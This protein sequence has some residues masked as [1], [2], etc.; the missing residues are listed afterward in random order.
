MT[1]PSDFPGAIA[2]IG[3]RSQPE[4][5]AT[6]AFGFILLGGVLVGAQV[7]DIRLANELVRRGYPVHVWW[8]FDRMRDAP[9]D[10][11]I[12][13]HWLFSAA[14]YSCY[15][16]SW[17]LNDRIGRLISWMF[18]DQ[19]RTRIVQRLSWFAAQQIQAVI[20]LACGGIERD[21]RLA[22]RF[23]GE[24]DRHQITHVLPNLEILALFAQAARQHASS[25]FKCLVTFQGYE[26]YANFAREMNLEAELY[27][28][29][30]EVVED[31]EWPA[32]AVSDAYCD[33]IQREVSVPRSRL[34]SIPPGVPVDEP[35]EIAEAQ[36]L[37]R[38]SFPEFKSDLPLVTY[39]GRRD[40]E[41]GLDL[42]LY[43]AKL[44]RRRDVGLQLAICGPTTFG[45]EYEQ[46]CTQ[47]A[48]HLRVPVLSRGYVS[49]D[50]RSALFRL[51]RTVVYPSIHEEPFGMVPVE[52]MAQGTPVIV[53]DVGGIA[54]V[55]EVDGT[56]AGLRFACWDTGALASAIE[57]LLTDS[58]LHS[59]LASAA[60]DVAEHFSIARLGERVLAHI[61]LPG[62][63]GSEDLG[64]VSHDVAP[65]SE[66]RQAA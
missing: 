44:L 49:D 57:A 21:V 13:Q 20:G 29:L 17:E 25:P 48:E 60:L 33:R 43:A 12:Q 58:A 16:G 2:R 35:M 24:L 45:S 36:R 5:G 41:K 3:V 32:V 15:T 47:I 55:I 27:R 34:C 50:L 52:A 40:S 10:P 56:R 23:A 7:R 8:A 6:P 53:P 22:R 64:M 38:E 1:T 54:D 11:A 14:R 30:A 39:V 37:V 18:S 66:G 59:E 4:I 19:T 26:V 31:S 61:G 46:A 62:Y 42:L 9:L 65:I 28:K 63:N 51:S